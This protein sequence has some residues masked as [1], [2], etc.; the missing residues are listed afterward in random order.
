MKKITAPGICLRAYGLDDADMFAA[1]VRESIETVGR[2]MGWCHADFNSDHA[3]DW[4]AA[5][6]KAREEGTAYEFGIFS[7]DGKV[8]LGGA[9]LNMISKLHNYC[10]LGYWVRQSAQGRGIASQAAILLADAGFKQLGFYRIE[11]VA[12]EG[13]VASIAVAKKVGAQLECMARNRLVVSGV[14]VTAAVHA[15]L[16]Q[17]WQAKL[18]YLVQK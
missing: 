15:L 11:I 3:R 8:L 17:D 4:F 16:P 2:W 13:N 1:V 14:P 10:N 5:C 12:A 6:D 7:E 9:G 18:N